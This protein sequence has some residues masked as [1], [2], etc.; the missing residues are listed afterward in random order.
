MDV[1]T[2]QNADARSAHVEGGS[3]RNRAASDQSS[4]ATSA[5][6]ALNK[7]NLDR[8]LDRTGPAP[9]NVDAV[10]VALAKALEGATA[11][12]RFDVVAQLA[13]EL[14]A[15]RLVQGGIVFL[16][17]RRRQRGA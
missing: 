17:T 7:T 2:S 14:E 5:D 13:R 4:S 11:A 1:R 12:G 6:D 16:D 10:E 3:A 8:D 9:A 15:R